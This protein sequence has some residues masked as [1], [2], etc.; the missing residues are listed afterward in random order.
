MLQKWQVVYLVLYH[1]INS[2]NG[3]DNWKK[4]DSCYF[5]QSQ[6]YCILFDSVARCTKSCLTNLL[7]LSLCECHSSTVFFLSSLLGWC[8]YIMYRLEV[9]PEGVK[10]WDGGHNDLNL[11][12]LLSDCFCCSKQMFEFCV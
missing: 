8:M 11:M 5:F 7:Q 2:K 1:V 12:V 6:Q 4:L 3:S 9:N 10:D